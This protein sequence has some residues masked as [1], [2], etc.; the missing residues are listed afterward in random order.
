MVKFDNPWVVERRT[1]CF[2]IRFAEQS[3]V[4]LGK[5]YFLDL[6]N[7]GAQLSKGM[8]CIGIESQY[9]VGTSRIPVTGRVVEVNSSIAGITADSIS[10]H[11][12][13]LKLSVA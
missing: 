12:W 3:L 8:P 11:D 1:D 4:E 6:P 5:M 9:W 13:I 7:K 10:P 2:V